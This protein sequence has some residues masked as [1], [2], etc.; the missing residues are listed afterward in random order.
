[1]VV[2]ICTLVPRVVCTSSTSVS[3]RYSSQRLQS[4]SLADLDNG[5][6][7]LNPMGNECSTDRAGHC[8][9]CDS[10]GN[11]ASALICYDSGLRSNDSNSESLQTRLLRW[12]GE[13]VEAIEEGIEEAGEDAIHALVRSLAF[14]LLHSRCMLESFLMSSL[15]GRRDRT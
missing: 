3:T 1:M 10:E 5:S 4:S 13:M 9:A 8:C 2:K 12:E 15:I 7:P 6:N 14:A 11:A